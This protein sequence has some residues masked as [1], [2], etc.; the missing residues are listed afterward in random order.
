MEGSGAVDRVPERVTSLDALRG[1][2]VFWI[3]GGEEI[4]HR[5]RTIRRNPKTGWIDRQLTHVPWAGF[6]FYGMI[7]P[8]FLSAGALMASWLFLWF[9]HRHPILLRV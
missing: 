1:F 9:L 3:I 8:M 6:H 2:D 5:L 4:F 7:F